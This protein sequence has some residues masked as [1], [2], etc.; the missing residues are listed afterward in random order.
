MYDSQLITSSMEAR[1][2]LLVPPVLIDKPDDPEVTFENQQWCYFLSNFLPPDEN[3]FEP[4]AVWMYPILDRIDTIEV[5]KSED[6]PNK[7]DVKGYIISNVYWRHL[8]QNILPRSS[9]GIVIVFENSYRGDKFTYQ[10]NGPDTQ[11]LGGGDHHNP[12]YNDLVITSDMFDLDIF[13]TEQSSYFGLPVYNV[14]NTYTLYVYPSD[15]MES[16][17]Y[18]FVNRRKRQ[19]LSLILFDTTQIFAHTLVV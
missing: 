18:F 15:E 17:K 12:K 11:Y 1:K 8:L 9:K 13:R 7:F 6:Y 16:S 2:A 14:N 4:L 5:T 19:C 10:I 3:C